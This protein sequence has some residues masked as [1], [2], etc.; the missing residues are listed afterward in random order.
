MKKNSTAIERLLNEGFFETREAALPYIM[1]GAVYCGAVQVTTGGQKVP[2]DKPMTVR[3]LNE[4]YVSKGGYKLEGAIADFGID[5]NERICI[6]AGACTGG[7]TDCLVKHGAALVYAVEV[8]FGQLAGSLSQDKRVVNLEKTNLGDEKLLSLDPVPTL[9]SVDLS[10]LSLVK[11]VPQFKAVM[12]DAGELMCLVK[13]LFE[14]DDPVAR[15]TGAIDPG[16]YPALLRTLCDTLDA[17]PGTH[18]VAVT[19]SP[20]TGNNGTHEFF[21]HVCFGEGEYPHVTDEAIAQAVAR[22]MA[23]EKYRK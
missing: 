8:G 17:Q 4:R 3:G 16:G 10:Y 15:R 7:F 9:G 22:V 12:H 23:L 18:A 21:L 19:H 14:T 11:A 6:D 20:V 1:S 2:L 13:P 5:V